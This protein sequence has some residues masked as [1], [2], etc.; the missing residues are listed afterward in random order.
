MKIKFTKKLTFFPDENSIYKKFY[1][2][3]GEAEDAGQFGFPADGDVATVVKLLLQ[4]QPLVVRV[5][6]SV[7]VLCPR[8]AG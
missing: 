1:L 4:F 2:S 5:D 3:F 8:L 6:D 7:L